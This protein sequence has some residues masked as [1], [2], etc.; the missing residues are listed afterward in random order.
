MNK[1]PLEI[2]RVIECEGYMILGYYTKGH[3]DKNEFLE[4]LKGDY[5][6]EGNINDVKHVYIKLS[7]SP[8]GAMIVNY[9]KE[10]CKGSFPATV[11]E[12]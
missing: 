8:T 6:H 3:Y 10:P 2:Q 1:Y 9:R 5:E 7:P 12:V 4:V 11:I